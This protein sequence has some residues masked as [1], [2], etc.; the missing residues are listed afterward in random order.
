MDTKDLSKPTTSANNAAKTSQPD[1]TPGAQ[2]SGVSIA[3][4]PSP[5]VM[6]TRMSLP[7]SSSNIPSTSHGGVARPPQTFYKQNGSGSM[8]TTVDIGQASALGLSLSP[9]SHNI[10]VPHPQVTPLP[11]TRPPYLPIRP[12][13]TPPINMPG[14]LH[15]STLP[16]PTARPALPSNHGNQGNPSNHSNPPAGQ[17]TPSPAPATPGQSVSSPQRPRPGVSPPRA[18]TPARSPIGSPSSPTSTKIQLTDLNP[19]LL[20]VLC[21]GYLVDATTIIECL[22]SFCRTCIHRYLESSKYCPIC[23]VQVHKTKPLINCRTDNTLQTLVYKLVPGLFK[24]EMKRRREFYAANP[25]AGPPATSVGSSPRDKPGESENKD[26]SPPPKPQPEKE[27]MSVCLQHSDRPPIPKSKRPFPPATGGRCDVR[28]LLCPPDIS[29]SHLKKFL[30][31]KFDL[32]DIYKIDFYYNGDMCL[33]DKIT[34]EDVAV[35]YAWKKDAPLKLYW[36]VQDLTIPLPELP[37]TKVRHKNPPKTPKRKQSETAQKES[38]KRKVDQERQTPQKEKAKVAEG[39]PSKKS[40]KTPAKPKSTPKASAKKSSTVAA[41]AAAVAV[42][43][44]DKPAEVL[45]TETSTPS[46]STETTFDVDLTRVKTEPEDDGGTEVSDGNDL[47]KFTLLNNNL[48]EARPRIESENIDSGI[49]DSQ[50]DSDRSTDGGDPHEIA[51]TPTDAGAKNV[52]EDS[53]NPSQTETQKPAPGVSTKGGKSSKQTTGKKSTPAK[54]GAKKSPRPKKVTVRSGARKRLSPAQ[55]IRLKKLKSSQSPPGI[56]PGLKKSPLGIKLG[57]LKSKGASGKVNK[58]STKSPATGKGLK[59]AVSQ[60][61]SK[62]KKSNKSA[63]SDGKQGELSQK[64]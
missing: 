46:N 13:P 64:V 17:T 24:E 9:T 61:V 45:N 43:P 56:R 12:P 44:N 19:H 22:H 49:S 32:G 3:T 15:V 28:Y 51:E 35:I 31:L 6:V 41:A 7:P 37:P 14:L 38:K 57:L 42:N 21:G 63:T 36:V 52:T 16:L 4:I 50:A 8:T 23:D 1:P 34:L 54:M 29:V 60:Q 53:A 59:Q 18:P 27:K 25:E 10:R 58:T 20:C 26:S 11:A 40:R 62:L 5:V 33:K 39:T 2:S 48:T 30:R 55:Q 47:C